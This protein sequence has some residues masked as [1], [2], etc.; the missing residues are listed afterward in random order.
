[1][2]ITYDN[3]ETGSATG[4]II[5]VSNWTSADSELNY[6]GYYHNRWNYHED[7][8][9]NI[10]AVATDKSCSCNDKNIELS[11]HEKIE[12]QSPG[13]PN[14][15][16]PS[17]QCEYHV[18]FSKSNTSSAIL[19]RALITIDAKSGDGV[20][21]RLASGSLDVGMNSNM[22]K[23]I[24]TSLLVEQN[25]IKLVYTTPKQL[26]IG[27]DG[28]FKLTIEGLEI[29]ND[30]DC[31]LF[32][33]KH[34]N[35]D[36]SRIVT[37]PSHCEKMYCDWAIAKN[38]ANN[39]REITISLENGH[40]KDEFHI[41]NNVLMEK[42]S[43]YQL[44]QPR[45]LFITDGSSDTHLFFRRSS[46]G[47]KSVI[48]VSWKTVHGTGCPTASNV[49]LSTVPQVFISPRYPLNYDFY[50][51]CS[52]L[53][54]A[55]ENLTGKKSNLTILSTG[56]MMFVNFFSDGF[57]GRRGYHYTAISVQK[58]ITINDLDNSN[59]SAVSSLP[60]NDIMT[61]TVIDPDV[62]L[63]SN[64]SSINGTDFMHSSEPVQGHVI[65]H[66][67][68]SVFILVA[69]A[70]IAIFGAALFKKKIADTNVTTSFVNEMVR[71]HN[72]DTGSTVTIENNA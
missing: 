18:S 11:R 23:T 64:Y 30:C 40:L 60:F 31:S 7:V 21:L 46:V 57:H 36:S 25:E 13:F 29:E 56:K 70:L 9:Q 71:F 38:S 2:S 20:N 37:I 68:C 43:G 15:Q 50:G 51:N 66:F 4:T 52:L 22:F 44:Q 72:D 47:P 26:H 39:K 17:A 28:H 14:F 41:W 34:Y 49:D 3:A 1:M 8:V 45:K 48:R 58:P 6:N 53:L 24:S 10:F 62:Q 61:E 16:C 42:Y 5:T 32:N 55:P 63:D 54:T 33:V 19:Q 35:S 69:I 12:L 59:N 27:Q 67:I 65:L